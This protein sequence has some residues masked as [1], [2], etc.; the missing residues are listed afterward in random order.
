MASTKTIV[1]IGD[2][3]FKNENVQSFLVKNNG[4]VLNQIGYN[5]FFIGINKTNTSFRSIDKATFNDCNY[6]ELPNSLNFLGLFRCKKI[7][8]S[9]LKQLDKIRKTNHLTHVIT[10]QSPTYSIALKK[11]AIWCKKNN[12][13]YIVNCA[14][15]PI[16][17]AQPFPKR[18]VMKLNWHKIHK[19]N[20]EY[21][22]GIIAVSKYIEEFY[23]KNGRKSIVVPPLFNKLNRKNAIVRDREEVVTFIYAGTPFIQANNGI[24]PSGMKDRLDKI[25]DLFITLDES[26]KNFKFIIVGINKSEYLTAVPRHKKPLEGNDKIIFVGKQSHDITLKMVADSDFSINY[27]DA[28]N[29]TLAGFSTKIVESISIGTPIVMNDVE[30][31]RDYLEEDKEYFVLNENFAHNLQTIAKLCHLTSKARLALKQ[32]LLNN[33]VFDPSNYQ[34]SFQSFLSIGLHKSEIIS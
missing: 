18:L 11:I 25:I 8:K 1:Y 14:D 22:D 10:Y 27:R 32:N 16:F 20:K 4:T 33:T 17:D 3:D 34:E 5:V 21:A 31:I 13:Q 15:I 9:I 7:Y 19:Y 23:H 30:K 6:L 2:F 26:E 24:K 29:M 12:V 28:N